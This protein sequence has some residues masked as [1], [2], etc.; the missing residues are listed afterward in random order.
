MSDGWSPGTVVTRREQL[1]LQ[2]DAVVT[3]TSADGVWME[4]PVIVVE[5]SSEA[6]VSYIAPGAQFSF[7]SGTWP[8]ASGRHPWSE[9]ESWSGHGCLMVQRPGDHVAV[10]HYWDGADRAFL[11]WYLNLQTAFVR[12]PFGYTTQD[13][14]LDIIVFADGSH[15][16]KDDDVLEDR[17]TEGRYSPE[18][19][20][21]IRNYGDGLIERLRVEGPWWDQSWAQWT[22]PD[23]WV[24]TRLPAN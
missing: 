20:R 5:D 19:V 16:V 18:L 13:L 11:C 14:E 2:P 7:P 9:R 24:N 23:D 12:A 21:W 10:W 17:V 15:I 1:G 22:P 6:L 4:V 3:K 8:T